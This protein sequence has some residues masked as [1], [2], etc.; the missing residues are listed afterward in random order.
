MR[1][2]PSTFLAQS[3]ARASAEMDAGRTSM[4]ENQAA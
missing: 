2:P 3:W 1:K 4:V